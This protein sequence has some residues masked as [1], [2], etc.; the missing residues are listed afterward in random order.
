MNVSVFV[1]SLLISANSSSTTVVRSQSAS[2]G[3]F[4]ITSPSSATTTSSWQLLSLNQFLVALRNQFPAQ[5][6]INARY[7]IIILGVH[8]SSYI[9]RL[10]QLMIVAMIIAIN[11]LDFFRTTLSLL[12]SHFVPPATKTR[13][14]AAGRRMDQRG[15]QAGNSASNSNARKRPLGPQLSG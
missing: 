3:K 5:D 13:L 10:L 15:K 2:T 7:A 6:Q 4:G 9:V 12:S 8:P 11:I 14:P 1:N